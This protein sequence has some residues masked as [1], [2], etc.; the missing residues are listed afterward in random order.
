MIHNEFVQK[1]NTILQDQEMNNALMDDDSL[2]V[3]LR[4]HFIS[5]KIID[6]WLILVTRQENLFKNIKG[7]DLPFNTKLIMADNTNMPSSIVFFF[8]KIDSIKNQLSYEI[9]SFIT[10]N[11]IKE[12]TKSLNNMKCSN[13]VID[14]LEIENS[15]TITTDGI[16]VSF[17]NAVNVVRYR[18]I[19]CTF[20]N[21]MVDN[22]YTQAKSLG[23]I[24]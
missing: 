14:D 7:A 11:D 15:S 2:G 8:K 23:Y 18:M 19:F 13:K 6:L 4:T 10:D 20:L 16:S 9:K 24:D 1:L 17:E 22:I 12:L 5:E 3:I 21:K